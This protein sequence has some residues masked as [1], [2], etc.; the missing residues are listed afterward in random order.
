MTKEPLFTVIIPAKDRAE[1]LVHTLRTCALQLYQNLEV[2]VSDDGSTD[3]TREVVEA[4]ARSDGR[5]RYLS[6]CTEPGVGVGMRENF[7]F[8]LRQVK[9]GYVLALGADDG[10]L[11]HAISGM[12]G[13]L[14][15]T[16]QELLAWPTPVYSYPGARTPTSQLMLYRHGRDRIIDASGF[17]RRQAEHLDY[18]G[19]LESPMFYVKGVASTRLVERVRERSPDNRFYHCPTPDGYSGIVLAGE[20]QS[21]AFSG[22][23]FSIYGI[24]PSSQGMSYLAADEQARQRSEAFFR[25]VAGS[26]M[27]AKLA[28]QPYSPL[29]SLMTADYLL[30]AADLPGWPGPQP[31]IDFPR[32]LRRGLDELAHGLFSDNR[33][34]REL[35]ILAAIADEHRLGNDFRRRVQGMR[36]F[37]RK[38]P[39]AGNGISPRQVFLDG[40]QFGLRDIFDAAYFAYCA[41][42]LVPR[43]SLPL[44]GRALGNSLYYRLRSRMRGERFPPEAAWR[45]GHAGG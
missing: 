41:H 45:P 15:A 11:P 17:L 7:E 35:S 38:D 40:D 12:L 14:Q 6:P 20:V 26:P 43:L 16:G 29:I 27:H 8:A 3:R 31:T 9:P 13:V 28:S 5:I 32:L 42:G 37:V 21:Y 24:S 44:I 19:D 25:H 10:L 36:K 1:Y 34:A 30:T 2:I 18:L 23:P 4:A 22:R 39:F 33:M